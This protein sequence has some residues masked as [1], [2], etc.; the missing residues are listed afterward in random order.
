MIL[1]RSSTTINNCVYLS[2]K[3]SLGIPLRKYSAFTQHQSAVR[4]STTL[5]TKHKMNFTLRIPVRFYVSFSRKYP[6]R[7]TVLCLPSKQHP[8]FTRSYF[9]SAPLSTT[10]SRFTL[11]RLFNLFF[12]KAAPKDI[13]NILTNK[14][15][16]I[17]AIQKWRVLSDSRSSF[18]KQIR[19]IAKYN[20]IP[21]FLLSK[22]NEC[23]LQPIYNS[24]PSLKKHILYKPL[25]I[26][27]FNRDTKDIITP[28][29]LSLTPPE[30]GMLSAETSLGLEFRKF[31][32]ILLAK[33][34]FEINKNKYPSVEMYLK[35]GIENTYR[36]VTFNMLSNKFLNLMH[37]RTIPFIQHFLTFI[38]LKKNYSYNTLENICGTNVSVESYSDTEIKILTFIELMHL[39]KLYQLLNFSFEDKAVIHLINPNGFGKMSTYFSEQSSLEQT[40]QKNADGLIVKPLPKLMQLIT[41]VK[42]FPTFSLEMHRVALFFT[43]NLRQIKDYVNNY[44]VLLKGYMIKKHLLTNQYLIQQLNR[45]T[46]LAKSVNEYTPLSTAKQFYNEALYIMLEIEASDQFED[47]Y[48]SVMIQAE[49]DIAFQQFL[50]TKLLINSKECTNDIIDLE[51]MFKKNVMMNNKEFSDFIK[52]RLKQIFGEEEKHMIKTIIDTMEE[53]QIISA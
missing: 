9:G 22:E 8:I 3:Y 24:F 32:N 21:P 29:L 10:I 46:T 23:I 19:H 44:K 37:S 33:V 18:T 11:N 48:L 26:E 30:K 6:F 20:T 1:S 7:I 4:S 27:V 25:L 51:K 12:N 42:S 15:E 53:W 52:Q 36:S 41:D 43:R 13:Q 28:G 2:V 17:N 5:C 40:G 31:L 16:L 39:K 47:F 49:E 45:L 38:H 34:L 35:Y 50:E 14:T